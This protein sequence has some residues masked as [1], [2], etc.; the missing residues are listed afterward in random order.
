MGPARLVQIHQRLLQA[1]PWHLRQPR[2]LGLGLGQL[3]GLLALVHPPPTTAVGAALLEPG[4]PHRPARI[5]DPLRE[6]PL[7]AGEL[8]PKPPARQHHLTD[9]SEF[10][11]SL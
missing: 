7:L 9:L 8:D 3:V 4:V 10:R 6:L 1:V 11:R 5:P 2:V